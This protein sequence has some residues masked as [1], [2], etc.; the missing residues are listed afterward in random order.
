MDAIPLS[1]KRAIG[2][3]IGFIAY[4]FLKLVRGKG[5]DVH[6]LMYVAT[7]AFLIYFAMDFIR[8]TFHI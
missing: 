5:G 2:I 7:V 8:T 1:L 6:S 3:G 4:T